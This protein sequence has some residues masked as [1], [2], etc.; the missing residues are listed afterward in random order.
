VT[1]RIS[2]RG[3]VVWLS[4]SAGALLAACAAPPAPT[5]TPVPAK[6]AEAPKPA[7]PVPAA[8]AAAPTNTPAP[9]APAAAAAPPKPTEAPKPAEPAKPVVEAAKPPTTGAAPALLR[10]VLF[11]QPTKVDA[12]KGVQT[13]FESANPGKKI[14]FT[15][16]S[17]PDWD[18]YYGKLVTM[19]AAGQ[20]LDITEVSTEGLH[21]SASR[22]L[23]KPINDLINADKNAMQE[24]FDDL[25]P[26]LAQATMYK[27]DFYY[28]PQL[29]GS[30]VL[31]YNTKLFKEVG[32]DRPKDDWTVA[33]FL[34]ISK[35]IVAAKPGT[36]AFGWPN[37]HWGGQVP[38]FFNH[39]G[40]LYEE[41]KATG[42]EWFWGTFYAKDEN[43]KGRGGGYQW[44]NPTANSP[45]MVE[46]MTF[47]QDLTHVHK[48]APQPAGFDDLANFFTSGKLA[49]LPAHRFMVGRLKSAG[50]GPED[51]D[52]L[53]MPKGKTQRHQFGT[54]SIALMKDNKNPEAAWPLMKFIVSKEEI[55]AWV[56][57]G[58]HTSVRRS[59][60]N[61][62]KQHEGIGPK[63]WQ[64]FYDALDKRPDTGPI[65]APAET[66]EMTSILVK[67]T[68]LVMA[69]E[70]KPKA[71]LDQMQTE[72]VALMNKTKR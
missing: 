21:L 15:A 47:L 35:K 2:R 45:E 8:P 23:I 14:E 16:V 11:G 34:D 62:P 58:V 63:N 51:F 72:L 10:Y 22:G 64:I 37:R 52:I 9:A 12:M 6:P 70:Q 32:I 53:L 55:D 4:A 26:S 18:D 5:A 20:P 48:A 56:R 60:A 24:Y 69:N 44:G 61:D 71:A 68:G 31:F 7:A 3:L 67:Y 66:K 40:N 29:H 50:V 19:V 42:G 39:G 54:S 65:P 36:F 17:A 49:M 57:G 30:A 1:R 25:A 13:R 28:L 41:P 27:G 59:V 33:D 43:A 38:W 46:A